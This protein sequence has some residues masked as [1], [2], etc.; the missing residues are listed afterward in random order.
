MFNRRHTEQASTPETTH[1]IEVMSQSELSV[2]YQGARNLLVAGLDYPNAWAALSSESIVPLTQLTMTDEDLVN[3]A[4]TPSHVCAAYVYDN[5]GYVLDDAQPYN[6]RYVPLRGRVETVAERLESKGEARSAALR[7]VRQKTEPLMQQAIRER[8]LAR[9][10]HEADPDQLESKTQRFMKLLTSYR[11]VDPTQAVA[12]A[13]DIYRQGFQKVAYDHRVADRTRRVLLES[14]AAIGQA[15]PAVKDHQERIL[16]AAMKADYEQKTGLFKVAR[17]SS[18][19]T[20]ASQVQAIYRPQFQAIGRPTPNIQERIVVPTS[21]RAVEHTAEATVRT[22]AAAK[23]TLSEVEINSKKVAA[24]VGIVTVLGS[25]IGQVASANAA[26][27][28]EIPRGVGVEQTYVVNSRQNLI[29]TDP[30]AEKSIE[31]QPPVVSGSDL[32]NEAAD[33][34]AKQFEALIKQVDAD[35]QNNTSDSAPSTTENDITNSTAANPVEQTVAP[36]PVSASTSNDNRNIPVTSPTSPSALPP[37]LTPN[38]TSTDQH[39]IPAE[40]K[41]SPATPDS[42]PSASPE[43]NGPTTGIDQ[44][45]T[46]AGTTDPETVPNPPTSS[47]N[48]DVAPSDDSPNISLIPL[49]T[50]ATPDVVQSNPETSVSSSAADDDI[51]KLL[52]IIAADQSTPDTTPTPKSGL[53]VNLLLSDTDS[54]SP[55]T[56]ALPTAFQELLL[57]EEPDVKADPSVEDVASRIG[58]A[59]THIR[60]STPPKPKHE[61]AQAHQKPKQHQGHRA[62]KKSTE[63]HLSPSERAKQTCQET[64]ATYVGPITTYENGRPSERYACRLP[65]SVGHDIYVDV[66]IARGVVNAVHELR[67]RGVYIKV[68]S[69]FRS[70]SF[71]HQLRVQYGCY[72]PDGFSRAGCSHPVATPGYSNH[73]TGDAI[74]IESNGNYYGI[75]RDVFAKN[76]LHNGVADDANHFSDDGR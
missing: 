36:T 9:I 28:T 26:S 22:V 2:Y 32:S 55:D 40:Q 58:A 63:R 76:G 69:G 64:G 47:H 1:L 18:R 41:T 66:K 59:A 4:N 62:A 51:K 60:V 46:D 45:P 67:D 48:L 49:T 7:Q 19:D 23:D 39:Q 54:K 72:V 73:Q 5:G 52:G 15:N 31:K 61:D 25:G 42:V 11:P 56:Q 74:D 10:E 30:T 70:K 27:A 38:N 24:G 37:L 65:S 12:L 43:N 20:R 16:T 68:I 57:G 75:V 14:F 29:S 33:S 17:S 50:P 34:T 35:S 21:Q 8:L 71:Q 6:R 3:R 53:P 13:E 44:L